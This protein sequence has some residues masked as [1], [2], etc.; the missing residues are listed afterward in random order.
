MKN[1][2]L[3]DQVAQLLEV[4]RLEDIG[5]GDH[6]TL[7][8]IDERHHSVA[9]LIIKDHGV[10]CGVS[11]AEELFRQYDS[12]VQLDTFIE[13]G[14]KVKHGDVGFVIAGSTRS[15]LSLERTV[16]NIMQRM[17]GVSTIT[18]QYASAIQHTKAKVLDTR[19]T[20][21]GLRWFEKQAVKAGGGANHRF[22]L[23]DMILIK[24][25]HI[26][27]AGS[28]SEA[29]NRGTAYRMSNGLDILLEV[30]VRTRDELKEALNCKGVNR[31][32][33]DNFTVEETK[34]AVEAVNGKVDLESSGGI[35]IESIVGYA[36]AG[37]DFISVG[38]LTHSVK[39]LDM[40]LKIRS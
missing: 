34:E 19:K 24:D 40:S 35:T 37:V 33:L 9:E 6:T 18:R 39:S 3:T 20:T 27:A 10:L 28:I 22:G 14:A 25:N 16:L 4:A 31:I 2:E 21:P 7:S 8:C 36:E 13:D 1:D 23:Y 5:A 17:S 26:D 15:I 11:V 32:M 29:V 30:E 38:A 12:S